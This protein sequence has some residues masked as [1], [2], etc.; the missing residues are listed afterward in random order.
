M[1][2]TSLCVPLSLEE[3]TGWVL[4]GPGACPKFPV[5]GRAVEVP[6]TATAPALFPSIQLF[7]EKRGPRDGP[8]TLRRVDYRCASRTS[9]L[10]TQ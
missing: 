7:P 2:V 6:T 9:S 1:N 3:G 10:R 4:L 8:A 5:V